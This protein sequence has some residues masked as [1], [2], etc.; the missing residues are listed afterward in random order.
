MAKPPKNPLKPETRLVTAGC[1]PQAQHGFVNPPVY[2][3]CYKSHCAMN[4]VKD[5]VVPGSFVLQGC[6]AMHW[7]MYDQCAT[8]NVAPVSI[9]ISK[10][11]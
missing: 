1:D 2:H 10:L 5:R 4:F 8:T 3:A 6:P 9:C 7:Y 11:D